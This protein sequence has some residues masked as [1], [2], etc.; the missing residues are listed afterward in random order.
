MINRAVLSNTAPGATTLNERISAPRREVLFRARRNGG[1]ISI[2]FKKTGHGFMLC[3]LRHK[4]ITVIV[5]VSTSAG[6][7]V[8]SLMG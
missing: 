1:S 5:S 7:E 3:S 8:F 2:G 6:G 4:Q